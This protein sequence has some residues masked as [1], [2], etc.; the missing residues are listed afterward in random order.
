MNA[1]WCG[2]RVILEPCAA[3]L[4]WPIIRPLA[5]ILAFRSLETTRPKS[6]SLSQSHL[7]AH[8][9]LETEELVQYWKSLEFFREKCQIC[10]NCLYQGINLLL[11]ENKCTRFHLKRIINSITPFFQEGHT[12]FQE[13]FI[14]S[15]VER[16][17]VLLYC[18]V[19][20]CFS[21]MT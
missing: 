8:L 7:G 5:F 18:F 20:L 14:L 11:L 17:N 15:I 10:E 2:C 13:S 3:G 9:Q 12:E 4:Q 21:Y 6:Q 16:E 1:F 19:I